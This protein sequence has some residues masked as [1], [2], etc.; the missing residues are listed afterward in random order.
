MTFISVLEKTYIEPQRPYSQKELSINRNN[1]YRVLR[2]GK[3]YADHENCGHFYLTKFNGR[4]EKEI[5][6][7]KNSDAGNCSVCWKL[8]KTDRRLR[9]HAKELVTHY[10]NLFTHPPHYLTYDMVETEMDFYQWLY[11]EFSNRVSS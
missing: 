9:Q 5:L 10:Y 2:L 4:K 8:N 6:E 3:T 7:T 1:N 11:V